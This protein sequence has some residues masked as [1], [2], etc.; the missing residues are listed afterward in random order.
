MRCPHIKELFPCG[1]LEGDDLTRDISFKGHASRFMQAVGAVIDNIDNYE[2][3]LSPLL[4]S[5]GR[6]HI[7]YRG[8]KYNY[9]DEFEEAMIHVWSED[10]GAKFTPEARDTWH[11]VFGFIMEELKMGY[12]DALRDAGL[13]NPP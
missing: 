2:Q 10:L 9:F 7:H 1:H 12:Q 4:N 13:E 6:Q 8:F 3:A 5:L 11:Q